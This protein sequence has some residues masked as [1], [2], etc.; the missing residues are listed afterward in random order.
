M[1]RDLEAPS[2]EYQGRGRRP[3]APWQSV[4]DWRTSLHPMAWARFAV[5]D[6][7]KGPVAIAMVK[8]RGQTRMERKRTGPDEWLVVTRR[9]LADDRALEPRASRDATDQDVHY[10]YHD[11]RTPTDGGKVAFKEPSL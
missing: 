3:K 6:G 10:R 4:T 7:E 9:P 8:R 2:P 5:R 1:M 11:Y